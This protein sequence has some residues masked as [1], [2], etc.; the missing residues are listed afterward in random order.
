MTTILIIFCISIALSLLLTPLA[1]K[2][3]RWGKAMDKPDGSRKNH[4]RPT[5]RT[6][7]IALC[8]SFVFTLVAVGW[9]HTDIAV[10]VQPKPGAWHVF[11]AGLLVFGVGL[12]DDYQR[13]N[14]HIKFL[15]QILAASLVFIGGYSIDVFSLM[16]WQI[17]PA[18]SYLLTVLWFLVF[19]NA[20]NLMDGLDGLS[21][22]VCFFCCLVMTTISLMNQDY[23]SASLFACLGGTLLG[24]LRY[25]FNPA[26]IFMGDGGSYFLGFTIAMISLAS[27]VKMQTGAAILIPIVALGVPMFDTIL[28]PVRR[29]ITGKGMFKPDNGHIHHKLVHYVGLNSRRAVLLIYLV[30][31]VL[32]LLALII[33]SLQDERAG[34]FLILIGAAAMLA[35]RKLGYLDYLATDKILGWFRDMSD[36]SGFSGDRRSF[37]NLQVNVARSQNFAEFW[38]TVSTALHRLGF[39]HA[40]MN[41]QGTMNRQVNFHWT[42]DNFDPETDFCR[43]CLMKLELPLMDQ[44]GH[45]QGTLWLIKDLGK[46]PIS[47]YTLRR[48]E[49]LRRTMVQTLVKLQSEPVSAHQEQPALD[50]KGRYVMRKS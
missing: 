25:N 19:I 45:N 17:G 27:S 33:A 30:S 31:A 42:R 39:D 35:T 10:L 14:H 48:I 26:S 41:C 50:E 32:C 43:R 23:L 37:L 40:E 4:R 13:L 29:F 15:V 20:V 8:A 36:S 5:P 46:N 34:L 1:G 16:G 7:G 11:L 9:L 18:A 28:S 21:A 38:R 6:G 22:G 3:G 49:H 12:W 24:F 2:L 44:E 47:H